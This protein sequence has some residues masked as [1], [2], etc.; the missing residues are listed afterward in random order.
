[1]KAV[2]WSKDSES[3]GTSVLFRWFCVAEPFGTHHNSKGKPYKAFWYYWILEFFS[4]LGILGF[5]ILYLA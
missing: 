4:V 2:T 3:K 1:M 5:Y